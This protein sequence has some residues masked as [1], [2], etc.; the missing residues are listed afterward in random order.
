M[1]MQNN[2]ECFNN[3]GPVNKR[4]N[5]IYIAVIILS[6]FEWIAINISILY[7]A[8]LLKAEA[9]RFVY[10]YPF[11]KISIAGL[12]AYDASEF[13][14]YALARPIA[15]I[16][17]FKDK[18]ICGCEKTRKRIAE[19]FLFYP[20]ILGILIT[21]YIYDYALNLY[22]LNIIKLLTITNLIIMLIVNVFYKRR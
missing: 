14:I 19:N 12:W 9:N 17:A 15:V 16:V 7:M 6:L 5:I 18:Y 21:A 13:I 20:P 11:N 10:I 4:N 2:E 3:N 1:N 22:Y 8:S